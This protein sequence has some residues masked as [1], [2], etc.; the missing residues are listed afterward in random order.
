MYD[1]L[2]SFFKGALMNILRFLVGYYDSLLLFVICS[3]QED[4]VAHYY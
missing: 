1:D 3:T 4:I 2:F